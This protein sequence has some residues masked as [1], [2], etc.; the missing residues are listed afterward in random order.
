MTHSVED[1]DE[2]DLGALYDQTGNV[3]D[4]QPRPGHNR[5]MDEDDTLDELDLED[6]MKEARR[7]LLKDLLR[8]VRG[9][10]ASPAEKNTLRQMLK[11]N[12]M[13][14]GDPDEGATVG[15][16]RRKRTSPASTDP[17]TIGDL[18]PYLKSLQ[19]QHQ[20]TLRR[21]ENIQR[22]LDAMPE[23]AEAVQRHYPGRALV[24]WFRK[25][26]RY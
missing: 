9:G 11:D 26:M 23:E 20:I 14:M 25:L 10:Y 22:Q 2:S 7:D 8:A 13:V 3:R 21:V 12:G 15:E 5:Q 1:D 6:I 24:E 4:D 17:N 18:Q 16:A 19:R